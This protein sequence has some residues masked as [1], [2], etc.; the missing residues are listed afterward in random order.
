[1]RRVAAKQAGRHACAYS[2][3]QLLFAHQLAARTGGMAAAAED[4]QTPIHQFH[5]RQPT[6]RQGSHHLLRRLV[7]H[8]GQLAIE[9][10][11]RAATL[12]S[13]KRKPTLR[14]ELETCPSN[15]I[16]GPLTAAA[17]HTLHAASAVTARGAKK[18]HVGGSSPGRTQ[19]PG[20]RRRA[21]AAQGSGCTPAAAP[22]LHSTA[23]ESAGAELDV[24]EGSCVYS[25]DRILP[26]TKAKEQ[27]AGMHRTLE[28]ADTSPSSL[29]A[30]Q[31]LL[32]CLLRACVQDATE[33]LETSQHS[34]TAT[35]CSPSPSRFSKYCCIAATAGRLRPCSAN[36]AAMSSYTAPS[37]RGSDCWASDTAER[38]GW[39]LLW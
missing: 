8:V 17:G 22:R 12:P 13:I 1:M 16:A 26:A 33:Q 34:N 18:E 35:Q 39:Q 5:D 23:G 24:A 29:Q 32:H 20:A 7:H 14:T 11:H 19:P 28:F 25:S 21:A 9:L 31:T 27:T 15:G 3:D 10:L 30:L 36:L 2:V 37:K 38:R 6:G 4:E